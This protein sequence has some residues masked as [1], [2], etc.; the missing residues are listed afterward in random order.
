M[1]SWVNSRSILSCGSITWAC[2]ACTPK[3]EASNL[4]KSFSF[5]VR[6]ALNFIQYANACVQTIAALEPGAKVKNE[7]VLRITD[8]DYSSYISNTN[9]KKKLKPL[10]KAIDDMLARL[11]VRKSTALSSW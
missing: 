9:I 8:E 4:D 7:D 5:P 2:L 11:C 10:N 1:A 6:A 3:N